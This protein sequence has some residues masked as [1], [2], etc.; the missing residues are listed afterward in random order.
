MN[1]RAFT[2]L[3]LVLAMA[4]GTVVVGV[5]WGLMVSVDRAMLLS[6]PCRR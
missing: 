2:L 3:E 5:A 1:R 4:L 6:F